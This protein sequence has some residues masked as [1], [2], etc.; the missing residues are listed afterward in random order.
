MTGRS[1]L[2]SELR[3]DIDAW[4]A[5]TGHART[6]RFVARL[7]LVEPGFQ[8]IASFRIQ[9]RL[10]RIPLVGPALRRMLW[11]LTTIA[12]GCHIAPGARIGGGA[13]IPHPTGIVI[14]GQSVIGRDVA[15]YQHVTIGRRDPEIA[16]EPRIDDGSRLFAGCCILGSVT[17]GA[18]CTIGAHAV[19]LDDVAPG[20]TAIGAPARVLVPKPA[21]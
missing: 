16:E 8:L 7:W 4:A 12:T 1:S 18:G 19:V 11:Y 17:L 21:E 5:R 13:F 6:R 10:G 9:C 15:I 3:A 2:R 20:E 14:G